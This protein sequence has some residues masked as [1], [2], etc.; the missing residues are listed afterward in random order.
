MLILCYAVLMGLVFVCESTQR[1]VIESK[2]LFILQ[3]L[4]L[5][6]FNFHRTQRF[7]QQSIK[8]N[9]KTLETFKVTARNPCISFTYV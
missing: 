1:N 5:L 3:R 8:L 9:A 7:S 2:H 6:L 4:K